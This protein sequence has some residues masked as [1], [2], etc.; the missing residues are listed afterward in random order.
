M[1]NKYLNPTIGP[2]TIPLQAIIAIKKRIGWRGW[3]WPG[4]DVFLTGGVKLRL[5]KAQQAELEVAQER[6]QQMRYVHATIQNVKASDRAGS[7]R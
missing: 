3:L 6:W 4:Y 1:S 2:Y 7:L 5:T